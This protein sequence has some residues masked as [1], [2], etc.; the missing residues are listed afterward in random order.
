MKNTPDE[1]EEILAE[2]D[3]FFYN[4]FPGAV[5]PGEATKSFL[6]E[7]LLSLQRSTVERFGNIDEIAERVVIEYANTSGRDDNRT[8]VREAVRT[9]LGDILRTLQ[10][11][12]GEK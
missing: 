7:K 8:H 2:F 5:N 1:I 10:D 9:V 4:T 3:E 11:T 12:G 6:R